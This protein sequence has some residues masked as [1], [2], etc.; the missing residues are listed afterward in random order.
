MASACPP[1][2]VVDPPTGPRGTR[3]CRAP[4]GPS[5]KRNFRPGVDAATLSS[6]ASAGAMT[7][8][9]MPSPGKTA[10][11]K[12]S[13]ASMLGG[14]ERTQQVEAGYWHSP[15]RKAPPLSD[16][17][18]K[19]IPHGSFF[20]PRFAANL[21][22]LFPDRPLLQRFPAAASAGVPAIELRLPHDPAPSAVRAELD[23]HGLIMLGIHTAPGQ[24]PARR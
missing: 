18:Y 22:Y 6:T 19:I 16:F 13:L 20:M 4:A 8:G 2:L 17:I 15:P 12:L 14:R 7:S 9:P 1:D 3:Q 23:R 21:A 10:I 11:W 24:T 5:V